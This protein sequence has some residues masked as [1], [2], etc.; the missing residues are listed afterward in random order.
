[1]RSALQRRLTYA[2]VM[3]SVA[4]FL[5]LGGGAYAAIKLPRN[6]VGT[7][8]LKAHAVTLTK[9]SGSLQRTLRQASGVAGATGPAGAAGAQ[10]AAGHDGASGTTATPEAFHL[11][12]TAG[13]P[14]F[15]N[16]WHNTGSDREAVGFYKDPGGV[17]HLRGAATGSNNMVIFQLPPGYRPAS[18]KQIQISA[19]CNCTV[20]DSNT[21]GDEVNVP[22]GRLQ[23]FGDIGTAALNGGVSISPLPSFVDLDGVSFPA[24]G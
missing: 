6:S 17:V 5:A 2:N 23:I 4:V 21:P 9:V 11:V 1:M 14:A 8:Q 22:T 7:K 18:G 16:G 10:G 3:A 12:D 13:E 15:Q 19:V 20:L 24:E